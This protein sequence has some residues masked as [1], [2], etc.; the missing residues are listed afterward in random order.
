MAMDL[1]KW[2]VIIGG[3]TMLFAFSGLPTASNA[4]IT[5]IADNFQ[6]FKLSNFFTVINAGIVAGAVGGLI[7]VGLLFRRSPESALLVPYAAL[8]LT[9]VADAI[10]ITLLANQYETWIASLVAIILI[11]LTLGYAHSIISWWANRS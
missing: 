6:D 7:V 4:I 10:S 11:P 5:T 9:F 3:L 8:L 1:Y 2:L